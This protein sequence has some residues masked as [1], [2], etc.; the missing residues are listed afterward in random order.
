MVSKLALVSVGYKG[1][2]ARVRKK[3][4]VWCVEESFLMF[5]VLNVIPIV[6]EVDQLQLHQ[7]QLLQQD[8]Q[9]QKNVH[10]PLDIGIASKYLFVSNHKIFQDYFLINTFI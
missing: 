3:R 4:V 7:L 8:L 9:E 10:Q 1:I 6:V 5:A 2:W